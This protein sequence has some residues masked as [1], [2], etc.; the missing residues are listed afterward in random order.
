[1]MRKQVHQGLA[2]LDRLVDW[3]IPAE[4]REREVRQRARMFLI[5]HFFGPVLSLVI[6]AYLY[7]LDPEPGWTLG[8]LAASILG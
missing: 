1:M 8:I 7:F 6:P 2:S 3:F 5:S 4:L